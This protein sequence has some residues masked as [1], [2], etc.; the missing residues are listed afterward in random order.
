MYQPVKGTIHLTIATAIQFT[1]ID[2]AGIE[3]PLGT[4]PDC[5]EIR[6]FYEQ[7]HF[8]PGVKKETNLVSLRVLR[9]DL[10]QRVNAGETLADCLDAVEAMIQKAGPYDNITCM[11]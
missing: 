1:H 7:R 9:R 10:Q 8:V 3:R 5:P 11:I 4:L 6:A 2:Y